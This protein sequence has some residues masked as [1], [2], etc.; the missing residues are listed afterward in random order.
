MH[1]DHLGS[2]L[3]YLQLG[4]FRYTAHKT[5]DQPAKSLFLAF[6]LLKKFLADPALIPGDKIVQGNDRGP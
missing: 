1:H 6:G 5:L 4:T 2:S 3:E